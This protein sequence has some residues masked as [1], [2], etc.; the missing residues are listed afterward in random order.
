MVNVLH[1]CQNLNESYKRTGIGDQ[2]VRQIRQ[3]VCVMKW[4]QGRNGVLKQNQ[5]IDETRL[6]IC[7]WFL[8]NTLQDVS[9]MTID[10]V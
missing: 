3:C 7:I 8:L 2:Q 6:H 4:R 10:V 9:N 1:G 5:T